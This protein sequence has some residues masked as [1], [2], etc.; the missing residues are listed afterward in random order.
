[1]KTLLL[2]PAILLCLSCDHA[3]ATD[4]ASMNLS[5]LAPDSAKVGFHSFQRGKLAIEGNPIKIKHI[6]VYNGLYAHAPSEVVYN[7]SGLGYNKLRGKAGL[8]DEAWGEVRFQII[9]DGKILWESNIIKKEK[10]QTPAKAD[11]FLINI[12]N[13]SKLQLVVDDLGNGFCDHS[14]WMKPE[15]LK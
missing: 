7:I 5:D 11:D 3:G 13:V 8:E 12:S 15:L 2:I 6:P 4:P 10:K 1:M 14:V 9:G